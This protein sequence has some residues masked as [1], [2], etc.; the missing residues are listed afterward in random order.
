MRRWLLY[1]G[2]GL[3]IEG[4]QIIL[5]G[6]LGGTGSDMIEKIGIGEMESAVNCAATPTFCRSL[7]NKNLL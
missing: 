5:Y 6:S 3:P 4:S 2:A 1:E 7:K